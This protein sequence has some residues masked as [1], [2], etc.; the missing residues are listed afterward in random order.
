MSV[1]RLSLLVT[2]LLAA[3]VAP[4][5]GAPIPQSP[6]D[7]R[8]A[9][10]VL[11]AP[12]EIEFNYP[13]FPNDTTKPEKERIKVLNEGSPHRQ[14]SLK[15][16]FEEVTQK[17]T[18]KVDDKTYTLDNIHFHKH[19]EHFLNGGSFHMEMHMVHKS[20]GDNLAIGRWINAGANNAVLDEMFLA[21]NW[22]ASGAS[23]RLEKPF[24]LG[25]LKPTVPGR[26]FRYDG[27]LTTPDPENPLPA[28]PYP[29]PCAVFES[30]KVVKWIMFTQP[31]EMSIDQIN[32]FGGVE[33]GNAKAWP[34]GNVRPL[35][36]LT[37]DHHLEYRDAVPEPSTVWLLA[38]AG[39]VAARRTKRSRI[40]D[41]T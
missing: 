27:S 8:T 31:L 3:G 15:A 40:A 21:A 29:L 12:Y 17:A 19:S 6:I 37:A 5:Q 34:N 7:F 33:V 9:D 30:T 1:F 35:Q 18:V 4:A 14:T 24:D 38:V 39:L 36:L 16:K 20:G 41:R 28:D 26:T 13:A 25:A 10:L 22:P 32:R 11:K 23:R 2:S